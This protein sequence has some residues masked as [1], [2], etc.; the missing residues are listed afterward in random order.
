MR[1]PRAWRASSGRGGLLTGSGQA[2][3]ARVRVGCVRSRPNADLHVAY[4]RKVVA[5]NVRHA[6][7]PLREVRSAAERRTSSSFATSRVVSHRQA[8]PSREHQGPRR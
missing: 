1:T 4:M 6:R 8:E 2:T 7:R 5:Q 3:A